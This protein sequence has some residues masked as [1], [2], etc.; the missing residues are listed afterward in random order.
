VPGRQALLSRPSGATEVAGIIGDPVRHSISP[1][2]H[3]AAYQALG[4]DWVYVAFPVRAGDGAAAVDAMRTLGLAGMSVTMPHKADVVDRLD[5]LE[6]TAAKL[7]VVNTIT[8]RGVDGGFELVGD[9]TDGIGFL[10]ALRGDDGFDPAGKRCV[11]L[12]SGGAGRSVTLAL[13]ESGASSV[14]VVGRRLAVAEAAAEL[15]G[16]AGAVV[17]PSPG[18]IE[19]AV[20][21]ADLVVN[22]SPVG[23]SPGDG[24][25]FDL[26]P[27]WFHP[28]QL[29][30]DLIYVP[31]TTPL[32]A[33]AREKGALA[34]NGLGM[35]IHQAASQIEIWTGRVAPLDVMSVAALA[36]LSHRNPAGAD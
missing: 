18:P 6:P 26:Q 17:E 2:I 25:P 12:G 7:G 35:L 1:A 5:R 33:A 11:V 20:R 34:S 19:A 16:V 10:S 21:E 3:N 30:V 24:L 4:I 36:A 32:L 15:A 27:S 9:S 8:R 14:G 13:A 23:M 28:D 31:G 22:S 29:V